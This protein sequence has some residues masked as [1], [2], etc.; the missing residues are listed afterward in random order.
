MGKEQH[1]TFYWTTSIPKTYVFLW[2]E[3]IN[4]Q[5]LDKEVIILNELGASNLR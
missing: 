2:T 1:T 5:Y 4:C 3:T